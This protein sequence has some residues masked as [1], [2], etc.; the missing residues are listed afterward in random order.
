MHNIYLSGLPNFS[1]AI[2]FLLSK[3]KEEKENYFFLI[4]EDEDIDEV[5]ETFKIINE[6]FF[7][8][9]IQ[10]LPFD[11]NKDNQFATIKNIYE[12]SEYPFIILLSEKSYD[13][14]IVS[15]EYWESS[16]IILKQGQKILRNKILENLI[17]LGYERT[18]FVENPGEFS[19]RGSV[20]DFF[21][22]GD[23]YPIRIYLSDY[24]ESIKRFE[25]SNQQTFDFLMERKLIYGIFQKKKIYFLFKAI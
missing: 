23:E 1:S 18:S 24:I 3:I 19:I 2:H 17:E 22:F 4:K 8:L 11:L 12:K 6:I 15:K 14:Q 25:I 5:F 13:L 21:N 7:K 10:I 20:I 16:K 9:N